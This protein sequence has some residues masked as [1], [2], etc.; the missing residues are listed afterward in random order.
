MFAVLLVPPGSS[1]SGIL[2]LVGQSVSDR[3]PSLKGGLSGNL[4]LKWEL[5]SPVEQEGIQRR[6]KKQIPRALGRGGTQPPSWRQLPSVA[7]A[8]C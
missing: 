6:R 4:R 3:W 1:I 7:L 2:L 5:R 8:C